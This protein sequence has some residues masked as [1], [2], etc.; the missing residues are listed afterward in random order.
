M[1]ESVGGTLVGGGSKELSKLSHRALGK[2]AKLAE[3]RVSHVICP[4]REYYYSNYHYR[5]TWRYRTRSC[6]RYGACSS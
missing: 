5:A 2:R 6:S 4:R 1:F 3:I